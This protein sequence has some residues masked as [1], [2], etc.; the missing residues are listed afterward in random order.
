M[1]AIIKNEIDILKKQK[2][3]LNANL[4][5]ILIKS[6]KFG[7]LKDKHLQKLIKLSESYLNLARK[8]IAHHQVVTFELEKALAEVKP[9]ILGKRSF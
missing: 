4:N 5:H 9:E 7:S 8:K 3:P 6:L 1:L 2:K